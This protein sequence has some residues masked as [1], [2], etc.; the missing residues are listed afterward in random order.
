MTHDEKE[1]ALGLRCLDFIDK[2]KELEEKVKFLENRLYGFDDSYGLD[3]YKRDCFHYQKEVAALKGER[4]DLL[5]LSA[6]VLDLKEA[7]KRAAQL[8]VHC[9]GIPE[10]YADAGH[11]INKALKYAHELEKD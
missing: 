6:K 1:T 8:F 10:Q 11:E 4:D 7:W 3:D 9:I 5:A 2:N